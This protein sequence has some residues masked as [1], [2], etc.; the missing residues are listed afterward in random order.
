M[1][2]EVPNLEQGLTGVLFEEVNSVDSSDW[3]K[4]TSWEITNLKPD[5]QYQYFAKL[6]SGSGDVVPHRALV[7]FRTKPLPVPT[8]SIEEIQ[9]KQVKEL[10]ERVKKIAKVVA[11]YQELVAV[12]EKE[13][14]EIE[15]GVEEVIGAPFLPEFPKTPKPEVQEKK[16]IAEE[17]LPKVPPRSPQEFTVNFDGEKFNPKTLE[18]FEGDSVKWTNGSPQP[19]WP[20]VDPH[21]THT[22]LLGFDSSGFLLA[23]EFYRFNFRKPGTWPYHDHRAEEKEENAASGVIKVLPKPIPEAPV[24]VEEKIPPPQPVIVKKI[25]RRPVKDLP[26][27]PLVLPEELKKIVSELGESPPASVP[28]PPIEPTPPRPPKTFVVL[29]DEGIFRPQILEINSGDTVRFINQTNRPVWPA[30]DPHQTHTG[31]SGFDALGD[32]L[33]DETYQYT[34]TKPGFQSYHNHTVARAGDQPESGVIIIKP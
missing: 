20:A 22:G 33:R 5:T 30:S 6:R 16:A 18:I 3:I 21:P 11:G 10:E 26:P 28:L 14:R 25:V 29:F 32:L 24:I 8:P 13:I 7:T 31:L 23:G 2:D 17:I 19:V 1:F 9:S 27:A 34:F 15:K 12:R 4:T